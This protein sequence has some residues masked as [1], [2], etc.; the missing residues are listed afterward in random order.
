MA[1]AEG[2]EEVIHILE[3]T[4]LL[5]KETWSAK[6]LLRAAPPRLN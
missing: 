6:D 5:I 1:V 4:E 3:G 2:H